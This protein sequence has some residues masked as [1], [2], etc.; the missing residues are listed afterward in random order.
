MSFQALG[1]NPVGGNKEMTKLVIG[2]E[3]HKALFCCDFIASH[4]AY[5]PDQLPW[6]DLD[7]AALARLRA[8]PFWKEVLHTERGAGAK[9]QAYAETITDPLIR[10]AVDL[11]GVEETRH[12]RLIRFMIQHYGLT[13]PE[14]PLDYLPHD[15]ERVFIDFGYG[16]CLDAFLGFGAFAIARQARFLPDSMFIIFDQLLQEE[17]RHI[18]FFINWM[19]YHQAQRGWIAHRLRTATSLHFYSRA[20]RRLI[21]TIRR[22][23]E[24][25]GQDFSATQASVFLSGFTTETFLASCL[26][27]N[28]RRMSDFDPRLLQPRLLP[29]LAR[30]ALSVVKLRPRGRRPLSWTT[31][32]PQTDKPPAL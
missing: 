7:G 11:Q 26:A 29:T 21:G 28:A 2:S 20:V 18:V 13:V 3:T 30:V 16:E 15:L 17:T 24:S 14:H 32:Q 10:E 27:E 31:P 25:N 19:A 6:P 8:V 9:V 12:A 22:G 23:A 5:E 1:C 4:Q